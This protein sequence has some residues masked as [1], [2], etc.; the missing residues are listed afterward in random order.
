MLIEAIE[1]RGV[2]GEHFTFKSDVPCRIE[3][4]VVEGKL[5]AFAYSGST[6]DA[7]QEPSLVYDGTIGSNNTVAVVGGAVV[8]SAPTRR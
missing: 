3:V 4:S 6:T 1:D 2:T 8:A 5:V 7:E